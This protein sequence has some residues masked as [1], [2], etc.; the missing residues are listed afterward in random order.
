M[1]PRSLSKNKCDDCDLS[2]VT[3]MPAAPKLAPA[4]HGQ[5]GMCKYDSLKNVAD[6]AFKD[7]NPYEQLLFTALIDS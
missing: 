5:S 3:S 1:E 4:D 6:L 7:G 2:D